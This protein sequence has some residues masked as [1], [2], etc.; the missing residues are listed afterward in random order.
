MTKKINMSLAAKEHLPFIREKRERG[1]SFATIA[2]ILRSK[3]I[4]TNSV[5]VNKAY[6]NFLEKKNDKNNCE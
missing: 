4:I 2:E 1:Y 6:N 5:A 3:G